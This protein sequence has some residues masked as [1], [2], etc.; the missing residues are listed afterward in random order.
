M[1][2]PEQHTLIS[3]APCLIWY[4]TALRISSTPLAMPS[5]TVSSSTPG[6]NA[7]NIVGSRCPPVGVIACPAG[8]IRGPSIQPASMALP[9]ATSSREPPVLTNSP[10][11]RPVV[12][13]ARRVR[14]ALPTA[15]S[16]RVGGSSCTW[17]RPGFSPRPPI[18]RLTSMSIRPGNK[19][20]SPRSMMSPSGSPPTPTIRSPSILRMP[21]RMSSPA[22]TSTRPA[23]LRVSTD[24]RL[25]EEETAPLDHRLLDELDVSG[26]AVEHP[27]L[28]PDLDREAHHDDRLAQMHQCLCVLRHPLEREARIDV[29]HDVLEPCHASVVELLHLGH[30]RVQP[31]AVALLL[32]RQAPVGEPLQVGEF[33][34]QLRHALHPSR[35]TSRRS[36]RRAFRRPPL[37][38][39]LRSPQLRFRWPRTPCTCPRIGER[40]CA[41]GATGS[42]DRTAG[43]R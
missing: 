1:T 16:T 26:A 30:R 31:L 13:P 28:L 40:S 8:T 11:W 23:A 3:W 35:W 25:R 2:P 34:G 18:S 19:M 15:R 39:P 24:E 10:R 33:L 4:R 21:G 36:W 20:E 14:R 41:G 43:S 29:D 17:D 6:M 22:S 27:W 12:K 37:A 32:G 38:P 5:S 7:A 9:S 42:P